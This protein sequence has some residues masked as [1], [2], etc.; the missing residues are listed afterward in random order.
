[1]THALLTL[2]TRRLPLALCGLLAAIA[3]APAASAAQPDRQAL[4]QAQARYQQERAA[5][6]AGQ[7][8]QDRV[9]CL[10]EAGAALAEARRGGLDGDPS[11]YAANQRQRCLQLPSEEQRDCLARM[12]GRGSVQGSVAGGGV[13]RELVTREVVVP[14]APASAASR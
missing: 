13:L 12:S 3:L 10:K 14:A 8:S 5:C 4:A 7:T 9:T 11:Q 2:R 1:M 6:L